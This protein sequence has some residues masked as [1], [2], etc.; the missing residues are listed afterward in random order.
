VSLHGEMMQARLSKR[1]TGFSPLHIG[2]SNAVP[3]HS[4]HLFK[5]LSWKNRIQGGP[6]SS[7]GPYLRPSRRLLLR[8]D[9]MNTT[10]RLNGAARC[11]CWDVRFRRCRILKQLAII[12]TVNLFQFTIFTLIINSKILKLTI[13]VCLYSEPVS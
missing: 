13:R 2:Q 4:F 11:R 8:V 5:H 3:L 10:A 9:V 1:R 7:R 12:K 6:A